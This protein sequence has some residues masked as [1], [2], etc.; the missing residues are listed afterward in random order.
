MPSGK[1]FSLPPSQPLKY[2]FIGIEKDDL[3]NEITIWSKQAKI[4]SGENMV[5]LTA[6]DVIYQ[7]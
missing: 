2:N 4:E 7:E 6:N 3:K 1:Q 5:E